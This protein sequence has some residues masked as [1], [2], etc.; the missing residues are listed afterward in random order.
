MF[1]VATRARTGLLLGAAI[2]A[3]ALL[4]AA[5]GSSGTS[6]SSNS[7]SSGSTGT[8]SSTT[9]ETHSG[10]S[11]T[12]LTDGSGRSLYLFAADTGTTSTCNGACVSLWPALAAKGAPAAA[13]AAKASMLGTTSR[14]DG[15]K[16][17]TYGGHPLYYYAGDSTAGDT[18][19]QGSNQF[20]AKWWL[21]SPSGSSITQTSGTGS[22]PSGGSS[23]SGGGG[24]GGWS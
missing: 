16:Q 10:P 17:V 1:K 23:S 7:S 3:P 9:V 4:L 18:S 5:C 13:G 24:G 8:T 19:G 6:S 2:A 20:G 15:S 21:V 11:G 12:Y 14:S 22:S